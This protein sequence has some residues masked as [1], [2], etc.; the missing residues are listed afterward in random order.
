MGDCMVS[1]MTKSTVKTKEDKIAKEWEEISKEIHSHSPRLGELFL[2]MTDSLLPVLSERPPLLREWTRQGLEIL[3]ER[4]EDL[5]ASFFAA[6]P[7]MLPVLTEREIG[8]WA[9]LGL[10]I[11]GA[12]GGEVFSVLPTGF[13]DLDISERLIFYRLGRAA[14]YRSPQAAAELYRALP[15][16]LQTFPAPLRGLLMRCLQPAATADPQ[17][18]PA[19]LPFLGPTLNSLPEEIRTSLLER[20]AQLA[21]TFPVGVARLFRSLVR[22]YEETG[23]EGVTAWIIAGEEIARKNPQAGEAFFALESRT[24]LQVLHGSSSAVP[25]AEVQGILH[26]YIHM[27]SGAPISIQDTEPIF[28]PPLLAEG[29]EEDLPLPACV[30]VLP[31]YEENFRLYKVLAA[32]QAGRTEFGTYHFSLA[33]LW[34]HLPDFVHHIIGPQDEPEDDLLSYFRLFPQPEK[35]EALFL[36]IEEERIASRLTEVY[37]GLREDLTWAESFSQLRPPALSSLLLSLP[38]SVWPKLEREATVYDSILLATELYASLIHSSSRPSSHAS[39]PKSA[40]K[41]ARK[42]Q[43]TD[44]EPSETIIVE[45]EDDGKG[46]TFSFEELTELQ[47]K[48]AEIERLRPGKAKKKIVYRRISAEVADMF[49]DPMESEQEEAKAKK[50]EAKERR[51]PATRGLSYL[52]DEWDYLIEDYRSQW[53]RLKE[54][55]LH[56]D[57]G[58]FFSNALDSYSYLTPEIK[59]EF[60]RLRPKMYRQVKGLEEGE[61][62]DLDAAVAA[63]VDLRTGVSPSSKIYAARQPMERD[64]AA[65]FLL[66]M[67]ASTGNL[68]PDQEGR[69]I[70]DVIKDAIVVLSA[71][72]EEIGD[73]YAICGFSSNGRR[74]VEF[75]QMKSFAEA[76]SPEVKGRIGAITPRRSTRMGTAVRHATRKMKD[77]SCRAK[78]LVLLSDGYPEDADYGRDKH[79]PTYGLRDTMMA[80]REAEK[81]GLLP[82]CLT[83]DKGGQDYLR[84]MCAPSQYMVIEDITSLPA[85][86]PKI[87]QR[88]IR[89]QGM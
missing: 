26:K 32:Q 47:Q 52:Y 25:L 64:V 19:V 55:P 61:E 57:S 84:E 58:E 69:R 60:K 73:V 13:A 59:R 79:A 30:D 38:A 50:E 76:L 51:S 62:I 65:L 28:L 78:L 2:E 86:L 24:S 11:Q 42:E 54:I 8:D 85:E 4:G 67:S 72:L 48:L 22:A 49:L 87:Y 44:E 1:H 74:N 40:P 46:K 68:L 77:V 31:T 16:V 33:R 12:G 17:P 70:I 75:Y 35:I 39:R 7:T 6:T 29:P 80:L 43:E 83:V 21:Q 3:A 37:R 9:R 10:D 18:L 81:S 66:D 36:F 53:C 27:L 45:V 41:P 63:R 20:I 88:H 23:E 89:L 82:F 34:P 14:A 71:A 56:G 5:A 15:H